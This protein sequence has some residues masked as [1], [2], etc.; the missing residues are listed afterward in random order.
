MCWIANQAGI[1]V[2]ISSSFFMREERDELI[3]TALSLIQK[4]PSI[5]LP[6]FFLFQFYV[7]Q[8]VNPPLVAHGH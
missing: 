1:V 2:G 6:F 3:Y 4:F 7:L 5:A 8:L